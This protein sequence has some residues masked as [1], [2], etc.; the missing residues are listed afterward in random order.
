M[1]DLIDMIET[2]GKQGIN[3]SFCKVE[4][5]QTNLISQFEDCMNLGDYSTVFELMNQ[6]SWMEETKD[7]SYKTDMIVIKKLLT[8]MLRKLI[9]TKEDSKKQKF[10]LLEPNS[11]IVEQLEII[12]RYVCAGDF[13]GAKEQLMKMDA[14][15][16]PEFSIDMLEL[17]SFALNLKEKSTSFDM[18]ESR[19][20]KEYN[21]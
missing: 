4:T 21:L 16:D 15:K 19:K 20:V 3:P 1:L 14:T 10:L 18:E 7:S 13:L 8:M 6:E 5:N 12:K 2:I 17:L 11:P 9:P